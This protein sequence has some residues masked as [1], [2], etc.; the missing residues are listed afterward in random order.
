MS[1][2][3]TAFTSK[4]IN[5]AKTIEKEYNGKLSV[6]KRLA[7]NTS[8]DYYDTLD[9]WTKEHFSTGNQLI[10]VGACAIGVRAIAPY[11]KD[12]FTDPA[13]L[14]VDELSQVV[15][16][17]LG[18]H[19][20]GAN[21]LTL[22]IATFLGAIPAIST[23]TDLQNKVAIDVW[24]KKHN[25]AISDK[26]FAKNVSAKVLEEQEI[27]LYSDF[28][29][30]IDL[31]KGMRKNNGGDNNNYD[32]SVFITTKKEPQNSLRL[33]PKILH[34]GI[35]C[36]RG[37]TKEEIDTVVNHIIDTADIDTRAIASV[38]SIDLKCN[39]KGILDFCEERNLPF[40]TYSAEI[41]SDINGDFTSS[42]FVTKITGVDN[43]CER[44]AL[45]SCKSNDGEF[46]VRK[47]AMNGITVAIVQENYT[48]GNTKKVG[49]IYVD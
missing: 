19:V 31:P 47:Q 32:N 45:C 1:L 44:S 43:V 36:R 39:E 3:I 17:L 37:K 16:P 21:E 23:A 28:P 20:G 27:V 8:L 30:E 34:L 41:L 48:L 11:V 49:K 40:Y 18:G 2:Y 15:I 4:G 7:K 6:P 14:T 42:D 12:K 46:I 22:D 26:I 13:V 38:S 33:I 24:A 5:L 29:I 9:S 35:G 10:F 25:L